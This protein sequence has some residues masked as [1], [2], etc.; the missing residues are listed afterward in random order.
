M[1]RILCLYFYTLNLQEITSKVHIGFI[2][3]V[4]NTSLKKLKNQWEKN[5]RQLIATS[6]CENQMSSLNLK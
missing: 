2:M 5:S 4:A 6:L 3:A 1:Y